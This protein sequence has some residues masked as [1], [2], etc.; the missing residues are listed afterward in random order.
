[1]PT[2]TKLA[3]EQSATGHLKFGKVS[4]HTCLEDDGLNANKSD[5][6]H[7]PS[8]NNQVLPPRT[9]TAGKEEGG[10][11]DT[12]QQSYTVKQP[13]E[14]QIGYAG[15]HWSSPAKNICVL[16]LAFYEGPS[17]EVHGWAR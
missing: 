12:E 13:W 8:Q 10:R 2:R 17:H 9:A 11:N 1:V 14:V 5:R 4:A 15:G 16:E 7:A 3:A 6:D